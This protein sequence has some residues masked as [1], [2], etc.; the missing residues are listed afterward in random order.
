MATVT[1]DLTCNLQ[2][3]VQVQYLNGN[4]FSADNAGNTINVYVMDGEEPATM[5]GSVSASVIR[6]DGSTVAVSGALE[7]NR[8]Y[9]ILPQACYAVPGVI[10][11]VI[12]N[13]QNSTVT[14]IAALVANV[15]Q[16]ST[17]VVVDPGTI[18]PSVQNLIAAIEAAVGSIPADY[19]SLWTSLAPAFSTS[20]PYTVGQYVT[21]NGGLYRFI[22]D[23]A[24]GTW[25]SAQVVSANLGND[26]SALKSA[27]DA[28]TA[29]VFG[30][31]GEGFPLLFENG[32]YQFTATGKSLIKYYGGGY[33]LTRKVIES[34]T[35]TPPCPVKFTAKTGYA[36]T[37]FLS[38]NG[39]ITGST[40][41]ITEYLMK[42]G[43][44][45]GMTLR[46]TGGTD[47]ISATPVSS[48]V[49]I[50]YVTKADNCENA[51]QYMVAKAEFDLSKDVYSNIYI[52]PSNG[53]WT[54]N[55]GYSCSITPVP[56]G[57]FKVKVTSNDNYNGLI[58]LLKTNSA[59]AGNYP[60]YA[61]GES[62]L[63][64]TET[65]ETGVYDVPDDCRYIYVYRFGDSTKDRRPEVEISFYA[66]T[67][68]VDDTLS[69]VGDAADAK[70]TG[71]EIK[72]IN[73]LSQIALD[74]TV[75]Q[76]E[77]SRFISRN[78]GEAHNTTNEGYAVTDY[79]DLGDFDRITYKRITITV[80][81]VPTQGMA[82]YDSSKVFI[83]GIPT[84]SAQD[85]W[86][87]VEFTTEV[88]KNARYARFT[89]LSDTTT[90]G[91][92][93]VKAE[94]KLKSNIQKVV[95]E[96]L[97]S[98]TDNIENT[99]NVWLAGLVGI[100]H[101][102]NGKFNVVARMRMICDTEWT[103]IA[104]MPKQTYISGNMVQGSF[105]PGTKQKGIPYGAQLTYEMWIG[106]CIS[107]ETFLSALKNPNSCIYDFSRVG[108]AYRQS[109][110]YTVN[111]SKAV[112]WALNL[113]NTYAS[114]AFSGDPNIHKVADFGEYTAA[115]I[116]IG[117]II[118]KTGVHTAIITDL[119][120]NAMGDLSQIEVSEA[121]TP[122]CR[123]K[124]WNIYG[125]F[126]NFFTEWNGYY[127]LRYDLIDNVPPVNMESMF[128]YI[129]TS[130]AINFGNKSNYLTTEDVEI[131]LLN[132]VSNTLI[133]KK[134]GEQIDTID[135]S[136]YEQSAICTYTPESAGWYEIGFSG[137]S[138][139]NHVGF[140]VNDNVAS[141]DSENNKLT[142]SSN[143]STLN[144]VSY[145]AGTTRA[146]IR[147]QFPTAIDL[148]NG[149][150]TL[151]IPN[152]ADWIH[153][154]FAN[155][156]GK[157]IIEIAVPT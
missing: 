102:T 25:N 36:F 143:V 152:N 97:E 127:L 45:Y 123:R 65:G 49:D 41:L 17:D 16:S 28:N 60:V 74:V 1:I 30:G 113:A 93:T 144:M 14:T 95:D 149:Y 101:K 4:M 67:P 33:D 59:V 79:V 131:T 48:I 146:H 112:G 27:N 88:P 147:D 51:I 22:A 80:A 141:L 66:K 126:E 29:E 114:G 119:V 57:T 148:T 55:T 154:I 18:I 135:V 2:Q 63:I 138:S 137:E 61:L 98:V 117:D 32:T 26:I 100:P 75:L 129:S 31:I 156:Y 35:F 23:H 76:S 78:D 116:Q 128:P 20:T 47:N 92:F 42:P 118:E 122:T 50:D 73:N 39:V 68:L 106:K 53:K 109:A 130:L 96:R 24:A 44:Q 7:G 125:T 90:H 107:F 157:R 133:V 15:Y 150:I 11:I 52:S 99:S 9:V 124:R 108:T 84:L 136:D 62:G 46:T 139:K 94:S 105:E 13:T 91:D 21:N 140:C 43:Q 58:A 64:Y 82:F 103:P 71:D 120:Y 111:C 34:T 77:Y 115:D 110:W 6:A 85:E 89:V 83:S 132:K 121:I 54:L 56:Q 8:A 142:F 19:S 40:G 151:N 3:A 38:E 86:G 69:I 153:V 5:G 134:D 145:S 87:Y 81:P 70:K 10:S 37:V 155:D 72:A 12:K 104:P